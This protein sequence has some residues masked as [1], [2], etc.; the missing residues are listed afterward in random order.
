M[1]YSVIVD[2]SNSQLDKVF[3]YKSDKIYSVGQRV[4]V[5]FG[6]KSSEGFI[7]SV[8]PQTDLPED[9][10]KEI[11]CAL[12]D[13][14]TVS[15]EMLAL[16]AFM[17]SRYHLRYIDVLRLFIPSEMRGGRVKQLICRYVDL[18][19]TSRESDTSKSKTQVT[20]QKQQAVLN[21]LQKN[22]EERLSSLNVTFGSSAVNTLLKKG[23]L[24]SYEKVIL[25]TPNTVLSKDTVKHT[26]TAEQQAVADAILTKHEK[27]FL[28]HGVTGSG[29]TE[30]YMYVIEKLVEKG[31]SC[32]MLVPEISLTPNMLTLFRARF[33]DTVAILHSGLSKGERFDEWMRLK[34]Q[35]A[36]IAIGARSAIF[37]PLDNVGAIIVDEEH[38]G[39][40]VSDSNP[41]Y[42]TIS[43][44]LQ[45]ARLNDSILLLGSA[46]PSLESYYKAEKCE[47]TLLRL[48]NRINKMPLP[49]VEIV[50]M[51][52][53]MLAGNKGIFSRTLLNELTDT[54]QKGNQAI[55]FINR[56]GF[57]SF[58][59][60]TKCGYVA[61]CK[62]CDVTLTVHKDTDVLKCH[63]CNKNY[64]PLTHCP[65]CHSEH[66]RQGKVGTQQVVE[67]L[68]KKFPDVKM[69]R[70]DSDTTTTKQSYTDI[71]Q[72]FSE[73]KAQLLVG[74][75]MVAKGHDFPNVTL[76]GILDGDQGLYNS[77]YLSCER[78]F[79]LL[80]QV[81]GRSGRD[82]KV[83]KVVLQTYTPNHYC[84]SLASKQD[85]GGFY[86]REINLRQTASFP[87]FSTI[88]RILY[89]SE[90]EAECISLITAHCLKIEKLKQE[91]ADRFLFFDKMRCPLK[92]AQKKFR[93]H[94]L[95]KLKNEDSE[96][97]I[98]K[99]YQITDTDRK[100]GIQ[101]FVELNPQDLT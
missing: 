2:I 52:N 53:E 85:Y 100:K 57:A 40:Y 21:Y 8:N 65:N 56:R 99:L 67:L 36:K 69:L 49:T 60:C 78:T 101:L 17:R 39:S 64:K 11:A 31:K 95:I 86:R 87:P 98:Q 77:N 33:G 28:L 70:M 37:A 71:L 26:L 50:D 97:I 22:G 18:A 30:V 38:D 58:W 94:I 7:I 1:T 16:A 35:E 62:D 19:D 59:M 93:F 75:Q 27:P 90:D 79:Q 34:K 41:R 91:Y 68:A 10:I 66:F 76:V 42:D 32:I 13:F 63:Y 73:C 24:K 55:L 72:Q 92:K 25:R 6:G 15:E 54:I 46:T 43:V 9:K 47:Y 61:K 3:T 82:A 84:L 4:K 51:R 81:A 96:E 89:A 80:T 23:V 20:S 14:V 44:A 74:T 83:G 29:K 88:V 5:D 48:P 45:R 12:D